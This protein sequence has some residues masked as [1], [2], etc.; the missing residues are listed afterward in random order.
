MYGYFCVGF[1]TF[2]F[3]A[4]SLIDFTNLLSPNNFK[5]YDKTILN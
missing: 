2:I 3:K 5:K 4:K 1:I